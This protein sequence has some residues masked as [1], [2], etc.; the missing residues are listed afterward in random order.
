MARLKLPYFGHIMQRPMQLSEEGERKE[1][2]TTTS[3]KIEKCSYSRKECTVGSSQ[4]QVAM[5]E[6]YLSTRS[7]KESTPTSQH[8]INQSVWSFFSTIFQFYSSLLE[9][10]MELQMKCIIPFYND[11]T[12]WQFYFQSPSELYFCPV[13]FPFNSSCILG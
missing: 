13:L 12:D 11:I 10:K 6:M 2:R 8:T 4:E 7:L 1:K 3:S 5:E 9:A